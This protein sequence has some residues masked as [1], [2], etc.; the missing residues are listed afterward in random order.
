[1]NQEI[2]QIIKSNMP[3]S[4]ANAK[5]N[6]FFIE[7]LA[8]MGIHLKPEGLREQIML[9]RR[10]NPAKVLCGDGNGYYWAETSEEAFEYIKRLENR[11]EEI[12]KTLKAVKATNETAFNKNLITSEVLLKLGY[13]VM[14]QDQPRP[15]QL[16]RHKS[17]G[18]LIKQSVNAKFVFGLVN[19]EMS[20]SPRQLF[21]YANQLEEFTK[22]LE[23]QGALF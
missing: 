21:R 11:I 4:K 10:D 9:I 5:P 22:V 2:T 18:A 19:E 15:Y 6:Q 16:W 1:M 7:K 8:D 17:S 20:T 23:T 3:T 14:P 13:E 12:A